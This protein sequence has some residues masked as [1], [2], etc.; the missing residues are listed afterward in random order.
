MG[1]KICQG[2][3]MAGL[4]KKFQGKSGVLQIKK[5]RFEGVTMIEKS[6][7]IYHLRVH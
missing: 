5:H 3:I 2:K 4:F 1:K 7:Q 6:S